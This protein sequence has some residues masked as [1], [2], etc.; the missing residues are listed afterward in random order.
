MTAIGMSSLLLRTDGNCSYLNGEQTLTLP[1]TTC[2]WVCA[3]SSG[4]LISC[5]VDNNTLG[6]CW[7]VR[8]RKGRPAIVHQ[9][10]SCTLRCARLRTFRHHDRNF[11]RRARLR[12]CPPLC[13]CRVLVLHTCLTI[14]T[15]AKGR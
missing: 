11:L 7:G 13:R 14:S 9:Q 4:T 10:S 8:I 1:C 2:F 6:C 3:Q 5:I 12:T 15:R